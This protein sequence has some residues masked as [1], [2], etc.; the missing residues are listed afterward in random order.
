MCNKI[1]KN[2]L[3]ITLESI[4]I[5]KLVKCVSGYTQ[6]KKKLFISVAVVNIQNHIFTFYSIF[7]GIF[8]MQASFSKFYFFICLISVIPSQ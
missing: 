7:F 3:L 2:I 4:H 5:V 6:N 1:S 8:P